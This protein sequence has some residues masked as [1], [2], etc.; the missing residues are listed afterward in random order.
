[1]TDTFDTR[2]QA[3]INETRLERAERRWH[4]ALNRGADPVVV[5][6]AAS[7]FIFEL[8]SALHG[9]SRA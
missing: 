3:L 2:L 1:M 8:M 6:D 9:T 4:E 5:V 7:E